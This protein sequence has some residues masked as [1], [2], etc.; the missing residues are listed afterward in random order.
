MTSRKYSVQRKVAYHAGERSRTLDHFHDHAV[1][2]TLH[3]FYLT[4]KRT[5]PS[6]TPADDVVER[7]S[8]H[9][10]ARFLRSK[11]CGV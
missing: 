9:S 3:N 11:F 7:E 8:L 4:S 6:V 10:V 2:R 5:T 1:Q